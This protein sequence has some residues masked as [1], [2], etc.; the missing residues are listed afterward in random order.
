MTGRRAEIGW[1]VALV[2]LGVAP[3]LA[4]VTAYPTI[5]VSDFAGLVE[6]GARMAASFLHPGAAGWDFH[7]P[8]LPIVLSVLFRAIPAEP[9]DVARLATALATGLAPLIPFFLLRGAFPLWTRALAGLLL[10]AWPGQITFSGVV[11]QDNWVVLPTVALASLAARTLALGSG[12]PLAAILLLAAAFAVR[13]EMIVALAPLTL[14][15]AGRWTVRRAA[16]G[17]LVL[18]GALSALVGHR[19]AATGRLALTTEHGAVSMLGAY[20]PGAAEPY[21]AGPRPYVLAVKPEADGD[22][23]ALTRLAYA[24]LTRRPGFHL[25]RM[26]SA[27]LDS[28]QRV[29]SADFEWSLASNGVLPA[30]RDAA[31]R[32]FARKASRPLDNLLRVVHV[33]FVV[34][35]VLG[36]A[37]R[38]WALLAI[39]AAVAIKIG[40]H[41]VIVTQPRYFVPT[42]ALE[43]IAIALAAHEAKQASRRALASA[44]VGGLV[45]AGGISLSGRWARGYAIRHDF[46][47][48]PSYVFQSPTGGRLR[49][50]VESGQLAIWDYDRFVFGILDEKPG[51]ARLTCV[52]PPDVTGKFVVELAAMC[53]EPCAPQQVALRV[54][55]DGREAHADDASAL[56]GERGL[57][58]PGPDSLELR[59]NR[60][61]ASAPARWRENSRIYVRL[62]GQAP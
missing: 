34:A 54:T 58:L 31:G 35:V 32:A 19:W 13:Q 3:R 21:W 14:A 16:V 37:R 57:E 61:E 52:K 5:P 4:F 33:L 39:A 24:E 15:C 43:L 29:D 42:V 40:L 44:L 28:L 8:G 30:D 45:L 38:S 48:Q 18:V 2:A 27:V 9:A 50:T 7:N 47:L 20:I 59:L 17:A 36:A 62:G 41:A 53:E 56:A 26:Y 12:S 25:L 51:T 6:M 49:C 23:A 1:A 60:S 10:A 46:D 55:A 11:A 22:G